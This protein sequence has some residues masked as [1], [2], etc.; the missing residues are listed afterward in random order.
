MDK[1]MVKDFDARWQGALRAQSEMFRVALLFCFALFFLA[2]MSI[3]AFLF[4]TQWPFYVATA[5]FMLS[6]WRLYESVSVFQ[7]VKSRVDNR[8]LDLA[9]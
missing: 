3:P 4:D 2:T 9:L 8:R 7:A 6:G 5:L 1:P